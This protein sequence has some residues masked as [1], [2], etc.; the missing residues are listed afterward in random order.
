M[1]V[2]S[3]QDKIG[4]GGLY[5]IFAGLLACSSATFVLLVLKVC[6][7]ASLP[8]RMLTG[9]CPAL[10]RLAGKKLAGSEQGDLLFR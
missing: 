4:D 6:E 2:V 10:A 9:H 3:L 1:P 8:S 7:T 5:T